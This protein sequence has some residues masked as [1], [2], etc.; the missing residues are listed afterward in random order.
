[1]ATAEEELKVEAYSVAGIGVESSRVLHTERSLIKA[2]NKGLMDGAKATAK[3]GRE[4]TKLGRAWG[5][6]I[7][8]ES[9]HVGAFFRDA[10]ED[11]R[12]LVIRED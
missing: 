1:M 8:I 12:K 11:I 7:P 5:G 6:N 10:L 2:Y 3:T 9:Y 4:S